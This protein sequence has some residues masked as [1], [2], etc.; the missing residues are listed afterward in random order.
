MKQL[1]KIDQGY[2]IQLQEKLTFS[3]NHNLPY[4]I[5]HFPRTIFSGF[6]S[7]FDKKNAEVKRAHIVTD[8]VLKAFKVPM[9]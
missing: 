9:H 5:K 8:F 6:S 2:W 3:I 1:N 4:I 7:E